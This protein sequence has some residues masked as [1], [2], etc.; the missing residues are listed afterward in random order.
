MKLVGAVSQ[1]KGG[2][3]GPLLFRTVVMR[4][5]GASEEAEDGSPA[6]QPPLH[7]GWEEKGI[8]RQTDGRTDT[9]THPPL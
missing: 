6:R 1:T 2:H 8:Q 7:I 5:Q 4:L 3:R 9:H